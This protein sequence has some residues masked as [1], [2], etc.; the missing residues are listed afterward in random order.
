MLAKKRVAAI[1]AANHLWE[2]RSLDERSAL[3]RA[4]NR[5]ILAAR[6]AKA[7][8]RL[9]LAHAELKRAQAHLADWDAG[10]QSP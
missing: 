6:V 9:I 5:A 4:R 3:E 2:Q 1:A 7:E 10:H 8:K